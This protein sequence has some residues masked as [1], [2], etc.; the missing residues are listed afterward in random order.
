MPCSTKCKK[1]L[2]KA[3]KAGNIKSNIDNVQINVDNISVYD[4]FNNVKLPNVNDDANNFSVYNKPVEND[5]AINIIKRLQEV[6]K[7]YY[8][9][10]TSHKACRLCYISNSSRTKRRK[11]Q[12]QREAVKRTLILDAFWNTEKSTKDINVEIDD[13]TSEQLNNKIKGYNQHNRILTALKNLKLDIKK[14]NTNSEI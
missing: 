10:H 12:Q 2:R 5:K 11:N 1:H 3:C 6:V 13:S 4:N 7:K 9:E 14:E 8:Q